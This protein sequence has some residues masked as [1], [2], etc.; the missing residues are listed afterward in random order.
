[1]VTSQLSGSTLAGYDAF[2][3]EFKLQVSPTGITPA[4]AGEVVEVFPRF[5]TP[6]ESLSGHLEFA[7][8]YVGTN[9]E[10][11][12][13]LF[14]KVRAS[15]RTANDRFRWPASPELG[16]GGACGGNEYLIGTFAAESNAWIGAQR[17]LNQGRKF[18]LS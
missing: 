18:R 7:L 11:L 2:V 14:E 4:D 15:S 1:M 17:E 9:L 3:D 12:S 16:C 8:K 5:L 6:E 13:A 10:L